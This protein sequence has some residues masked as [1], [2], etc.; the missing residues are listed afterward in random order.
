MARHRILKID[1]IH[2]RANKQTGWCR[3]RVASIGTICGTVR[4]QPHVGDTVYLSGTMVSNVQ[5]RCI[6]VENIVVHPAVDVDAA[7]KFLTKAGFF[8]RS[9]RPTLSEIRTWCQQSPEIVEQHG[10]WNSLRRLHDDLD[11]F[12]DSVEQV[13]GYPYW[14]RQLA[15]FEE[16]LV[17]AQYPI[18]HDELVYYVYKIQELDENAGFAPFAHRFEVCLRYDIFRWSGWTR[19]QRFVIAQS[20]LTHLDSDPLQLLSLDGIGEA[21]LSKCIS[22]C[23][24]NDRQSIQ[25][26]EFIMRCRRGGHTLVSLQENVNPRLLDRRHV[27]VLPRLQSVGTRIHIEAELFL[28]R[29]IQTTKTSLAVTPI[30]VDPRMDVDQLMCIQNA[31]QHMVSCVQG[32]PGTGKTWVI[33]ELVQRIQD[34]GST[35]LVLA[36]T[37]KAAQNLYELGA[38]TI[39]KFL[40]S[41]GRASAA[42]WVIVDES[43]MVDSVLLARLVH[44]VTCTKQGC[45]SFCTC[46]S[47]DLVHR[48][49]VLVGDH[50]QLD[51]ID[52]GAPFRDFVCHVGVPTSFL[53]RSY[54]SAHAPLL[55]AAV[56]HVCEG[57]MPKIDGVEV[58]LLP[59]SALHSLED[60]IATI[61]RSLSDASF[62]TPLT[63][64]PICMS[65]TRKHA[66]DCHEWFRKQCQQNPL[67]KTECA[68][69]NQTDSFGDFC[70]GDLVMQLQ[71][72][73]VS[74][75]TED[76]GDATDSVQNGQRGRVLAT[77]DTHLLVYFEEIQRAIPYSKE[78]LADLA[79]GFVQTVHKFQGSQAELSVL[80]LEEQHMLL[81]R[82]LLYTAMSRAQ[83]RCILV[84]SSDLLAT[85]VVKTPI[86]R[87]TYLQRWGES[88]R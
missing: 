52:A 58:Q 61:I 36:P 37:G 28:Q 40:Y 49:W 19:S 59:V 81:H 62:E 67:W 53:R 55:T 68:L 23:L 80:F 85:A 44:Q 57:V 82:Q 73:K 27:K 16:V 13:N 3:F 48:R 4:L 1:A 56:N 22:S 74:F 17:R 9:R 43:S 42:A 88:F 69:P 31:F 75:F 25:T 60:V 5:Y 6:D 34:R 32:P 47:K 46:Q 65:L 54:R 15:E 77:F 30:D 2:P 35:A 83:R 50:H 12:L 64:F 71:N 78:H 18:R 7:L 45:N 33:R 76:G 63:D 11:T 26:L 39:H 21:S 41:R 70:K 24:P 87:N 86:V 8:K 66:Q 72:R 29:W 84:G 14:A 38:S 10:I 79:S 51:P 20:D